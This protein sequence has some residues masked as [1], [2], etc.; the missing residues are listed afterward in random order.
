[1]KYTKEERLEI[2]RRIYE[3]E[4]NRSQAA[5]EYDIDVYTARDYMRLYKASVTQKTAG[6]PNA[7]TES[8][9]KSPGRGKQTIDRSPEG[10]PYE[11]MT[12]TELLR[13]IRRLTQ[14]NKEG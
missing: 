8:G 3:K 13:E 2:G 4:I 11:E 6:G 7:V 1:M 10:K 14:Q 9:K 12:K 5:L